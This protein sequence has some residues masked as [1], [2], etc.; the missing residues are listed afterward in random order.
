MNGAESYDQWIFMA[1][2]PRL[3]GRAQIPTP[4]QAQE[5][6]GPQ[7]PAPQAGGQKK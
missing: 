6:A 1:G 4:G 3:L 7:G 5:T 2:R